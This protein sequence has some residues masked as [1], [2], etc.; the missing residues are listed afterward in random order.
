MGAG[1]PDMALDF[2]AARWNMVEEQL[3]GRGISD[4]AVLAAF[5]K[6]PR[7]EFVQARFRGQ[8]YRDSPLPIG[9]GQT[10][11]QP[12]MVA[13][14][15]EVAEIRPDLR[16]LEIGT[17]SGYQAAILAELGACVFSVER[18]PILGERARQVLETLGYDVAV[19]IGDGTLGWPE[20]A[21]F[22]RVLVT[23]GAPEVPAPLIAQLRMGGRAI[24]P[25]D[26]GFSQVLCVFEKTPGG[27]IEERRER[28]TFVPLIGEFGWKS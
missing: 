7:H 19:H 1:F 13:A 6:V 26:D 5:L 27:I 3:R 18:L 11:S 2:E 24:I 8:A 9:E 14:M 17:G 20:E 28:C 4:P 10:I 12:Y 16:V 23:A 25:V 21:P 22:D 15:T